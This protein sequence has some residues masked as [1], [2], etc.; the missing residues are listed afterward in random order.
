MYFI[1]RSKV[2]IKDVPP[3]FDEIVA[4][5]RHESLDVPAIATRSFDDGGRVRARS[6]ADRVA[7][8]LQQHMFENEILHSAVFLRTE[9][10]L[11]IFF[12]SQSPSPVIKGGIL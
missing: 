4:A 2:K 8:D 5:A 1:Q 10:A 12:V 3:D 6:P 9:W 7:A 11:L